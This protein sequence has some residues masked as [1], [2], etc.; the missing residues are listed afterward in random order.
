MTKDE[1]KEE[2][3]NCR[4]SLIDLY[5]IIEEK[6]KIKYIIYEKRGRPRKNS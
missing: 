3:V 2:M 5:Y 4:G 1:V 6:Y